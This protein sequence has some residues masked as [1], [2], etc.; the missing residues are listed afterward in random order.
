MSGR[1]ETVRRASLWSDCS[2]KI[3]LFAEAKAVERPHDVLRFTEY[4]G[5]RKRVAVAAQGQPV[6]YSLSPKLHASRLNG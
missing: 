1:L 4:R 5:S 2:L 6:L 3:I